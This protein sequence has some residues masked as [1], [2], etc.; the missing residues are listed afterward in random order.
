MPQLLIIGKQQI[1][2]QTLTTSP[3]MLREREIF[4]VIGKYDTNVNTK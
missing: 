3:V 2:F 1:N 4:S